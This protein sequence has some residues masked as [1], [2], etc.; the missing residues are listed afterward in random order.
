[1]AEIIPYL[2]SSQVPS[3]SNYPKEHLQHP[4]LVAQISS[5]LAKSQWKSS[6][7][8][9]GILQRPNK[10]YDILVIGTTFRPEYGDNE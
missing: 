5:Y 8:R 10:F 9:T 6:R 3:K 1:M 4:I 7:N 2:R